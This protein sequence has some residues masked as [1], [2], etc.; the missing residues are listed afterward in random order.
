MDT[1]N[2]TSGFIDP[3]EIPFE[4]QVRKTVLGHYTIKASYMEDE[5]MDSFYSNR[6]ESFMKYLNI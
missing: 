5:D 4:N 3:D 6:Y 2:R 1:F